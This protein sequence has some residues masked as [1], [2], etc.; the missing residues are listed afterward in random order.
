[1]S[2]SLEV[3]VLTVNSPKYAASQATKEKGGAAS[4][5]KG[6]QAPSFKSGHVVDMKKLK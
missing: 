4:K 1:M 3:G 5:K 6:H 2:D